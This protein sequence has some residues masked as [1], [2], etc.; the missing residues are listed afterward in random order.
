MTE[1]SKITIPFTRPY[2][3]DSD[4]NS[5]LEVLK[6]TQITR[7]R[8]TK[9]LESKIETLC[10]VPY[11]VAFSSGSTA[12][13]ASVL[14]QN[15]SPT[16]RGYVPANTFAA[17]GN[18]IL[19]RNMDLLLLDVDPA[20]GMIQMEE[21]KN[22][23]P[24]NGI[25]EST[26]P[27]HVL[28]PVH[29]GGS[30]LDMPSIS[31]HTGGCEL[32][33]IEDAAQA[34]GSKYKNGE[35]VG[36]SRYSD[37]TI[38]SLHATKN[39]AAGE[40]GIVTTRSKTLAERLIKIRNSGLDFQQT[41]E[42]TQKRQLQGPNVSTLGCN[43]HLTEMQ[44]ALAL[45]QLGRIEEKQQLRWK[46]YDRYASAML[47]HSSSSRMLPL[48]RDILPCIA[49]LS[50]ATL[51]FEQ[52]CSPVE[53]KRLKKISKKKQ[54]IQDALMHNGIGTSVHYQPLYRHTFYQQR[55][56][57]LNDSSFADLESLIDTT[58]PGMQLFQHRTLSLPL[59]DDMSCE[60]V[61]RVIDQYLYAERRYKF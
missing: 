51:G 59:Y 15:L 14:A 13:W 24:Q 32:V 5:V 3:T 34:L 58:F 21:L 60:E 9:A 53:S 26:S 49:P 6:T 19:A 1:P 20:T 52:S 11:A 45:S 46:I 30:V 40:G 41:S 27:G 16:A 47:K 36:C 2:I 42:S 54:K 28:F 31:R 33:I 56:R 50:I 8:A 18:C 10:D 44:A 22:V 38:F 7:Y 61:Q 57:Q 17:T 48:E 29:Y 25:D 4:R 37:C 35:P 23:L 39:I 12:L 43:F 55:L